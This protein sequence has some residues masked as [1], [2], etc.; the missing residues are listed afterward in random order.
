MVNKRPSAHQLREQRQQEAIIYGENA[1]RA[2]FF[3][4]F[5]DV[6]KAFFTPETAP[7]FSDA[8][9]AL[10]SER[11]AYKVVD[12]EELERIT[13]SQ[14]HGGVS[15]TV[16]KPPVLSVQGYLKGMADVERD[17]V[18][19]LENIGNP[20]NLGAI[21]RSAAHF[22]VKGIIL[23]EPDMLFSGSAARVAE[24]GA[25]VLYPIAAADFAQALS[26]FRKAGYA[27]ITTSSHRG[28]DLYQ[29]RLPDKVVI[30]FGEESSGI[31]KKVAAMGDLPIN[32]PGTG[33]VESLNVSVAT[34]LIL[35]EW[36]RQAD[37]SK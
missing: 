25:E 37:T 11:K 26:V 6:I 18:L 16:R 28:T 17:C 23:P 7:R 32:I 2:A 3:N 21:M 12:D 34:A 14:H 15:I 24:G 36:W 5:D 13:A 4:R 20:H 33:A 29:S 10:A 22:G 19:A 1:C 35:G 31:S 30:V 27:L 8:M 9:R